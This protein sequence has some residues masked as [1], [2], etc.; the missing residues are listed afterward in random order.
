MTPH[1]SPKQ[2]KASFLN[3]LVTIVTLI[4]F[5]LKSESGVLILYTYGQSVFD[6]NTVNLL[7]NNMIVSHGM[8]LFCAPLT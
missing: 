4:S 2:N 8:A 6:N 3:P 1:P 5:L 7:D